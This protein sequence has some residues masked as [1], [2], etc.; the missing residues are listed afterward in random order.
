M[1]L[2]SVYSQANL[3]GTAQKYIGQNVLLNFIGIAGI[4]TGDI[5][6]DDKLI[7]SHSG[8]NHNFGEFL[9]KWM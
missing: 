1:F 7:R 9:G 4:V 8:K 6:V 3:F 5:N 2:L